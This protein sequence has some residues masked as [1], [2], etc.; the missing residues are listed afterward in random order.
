M[1]RKFKKLMWLSI[2][3]LK[4]KKKLKSG[5]RSSSACNA[6]KFFSVESWVSEALVYKSYFLTEQLFYGNYSKL[7]SHTNTVISHAFAYSSRWRRKPWQGLFFQIPIRTGI[8]V[9]EEPLCGC[10]LLHQNH[11]ILYI[12]RPRRDFAQKAKLLR[13]H[14]SNSR[15]Y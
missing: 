5:S 8:R 2:N 3:I 11:Y 4:K 7:D 6:L 9:D 10:D 1:C 14:S 15:V 12:Y 13:R